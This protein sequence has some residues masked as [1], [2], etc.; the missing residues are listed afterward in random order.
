MLQN[1]SSQWNMMYRSNLTSTNDITG[2][3]N[4]KDLKDN[5]NFLSYYESSFHFFIKRIHHFLNLGSNT[6]SSTLTLNPTKVSVGGYGETSF[7]SDLTLLATSLGRSHTLT[8]GVLNPLYSG[9]SFKKVLSNKLEL[10][11]TKDIVLPTWDYDFLTDDQLDFIFN[12]TNLV[13]G[14]SNSIKFFETNFDSKY[15]YG[16]DLS[17]NT[18]KPSGRGLNKLLPTLLNDD[19]RL[20]KDI[21]LISLLYSDDKR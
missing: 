8:N 4:F 21:Y 10:S 15:S 14:G 19:S 1:L 12:T 7:T 9:V 13:T 2:V 3:R 16:G 6:I 18:S 11:L 17:F 5:F 20:L